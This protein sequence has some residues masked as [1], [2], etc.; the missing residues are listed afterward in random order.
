MDDQINCFT[1]MNMGSNKVTSSATPSTINDLTNVDY[2]IKTYTGMI[3]MFPKSI[4]PTGWLACDGSAVS[5]TTYSALYNLITTTFGAGNG[6]TT[7]NLPDLR[8]LFIRGYNGTRSIGN[9]QL[10]A[11]KSHKHYIDTSHTHTYLQYD[12][13][14]SGNLY[15]DIGSP[16]FVIA[17]DGPEYDKVLTTG[18]ATSF[19]NMNISVMYTGTNLTGNTE[20]RPKNLCLL[21]C[22]K[23]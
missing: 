8:N 9:I 3:A 5:R 17:G 15:D 20:T 18:V 7:F 6:S 4:P 10:D 19:S 14:G 2:V 12:P 21:Y 13:R 11:F 23:Y 1:N 22:I 16:D